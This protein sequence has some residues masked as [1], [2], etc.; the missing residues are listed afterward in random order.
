MLRVTASPVYDQLVANLRAP[1]HPALGINLKDVVIRQRFQEQH[2]NSNMTGNVHSTVNGGMVSGALARATGTFT[3]DDNDFSGG[4]EIVIGD[5]TLVSGVDYDVGGTSNDTAVLIVAA[6]D[7]IPGYDA[8]AP[9]GGVVSISGKKGI[10][11]NSE[12]FTLTV[13]GAIDNF[14]NISPTNGKFGNA[15]P[16]QGPPGIV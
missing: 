4:S 12:T 6:I 9:G 15:G 7:R 3:V 5:I 10:Q 11:G 8:T 14:S 2:V 1:T 13:F 16:S